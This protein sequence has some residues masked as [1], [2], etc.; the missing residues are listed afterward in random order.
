MNSN[1]NYFAIYNN[2]NIPAYIWGLK[3][4]PKLEGIE[5]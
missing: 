2:G 5:A 3:R 4:M 1:N